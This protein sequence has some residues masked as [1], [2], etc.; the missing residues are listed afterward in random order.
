MVKIADTEGVVEDIQFRVTILRDLEGNKHFVPNGQ[1]TVSSNYTAVYARPVIDIGIAY[2]AD[3]NHALAVMKDELDRM[4]EEER[5]APVFEGEPEVLGVQDL[6]DSSVVL[7]ARM[8][9]LADERW[10]V[11]R[12]ARRRMKLRFDQ[13]GIEIPYPHLTVYQGEAESPNPL[14]G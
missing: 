6:A 14:S 2:K 12:E 7:R 4:A 10:T 5:W 8:Q 1:I 11:L 3:I 13:E 9:V